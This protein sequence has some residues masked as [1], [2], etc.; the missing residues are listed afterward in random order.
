MRSIKIAMLIVVAWCGSNSSP[1]QTWTQTSAPSNSWTTI[2]SSADGSKMAASAKNGIWISTNSGGT[3]IQASPPDTN[4]V[5]VVL[6]ADGS[7]LAAITSNL[8]FISTDMGATWASNVVSNNAGSSLMGSI[9]SSADGNTLV[10]GFMGGPIDISTNSGTTWTACWWGNET[11]EPNPSYRDWTSLGSSADGTKL[12]TTGGGLTCGR[13]CA[14]TN[15]GSTWRDISINNGFATAQS[16]A[17]SPNGNT[18]A[19][20]GNNLYGSGAVFTSTNFGITWAP[21][22]PPTSIARDVAVSADGT[23][24]AAVF[25]DGGIYTSTNSGS[26]WTSNK[27]AGVSWYSVASSADGNILIA[28]EQHGGIWTCRTTPSPQL[29]LAPLSASLT[30]AWMVPSTNFVMQQSSDLLNWADMTNQ[31]V[32]NLT[33]LQD[34]VILPPPGSNVFYR[35]KTP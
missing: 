26:T 15:S 29:S 30:L 13:L 7:Q 25:N 20:V 2:A 3:W 11:H 18:L 8:V 14:S 4:W 32:L 17:I 23:R 6:S 10:V 21:F 1:A 31:P 28:A 5:S 19:F 35:L 12:F 24:L 22:Y 33:N 16:V 9:A 27:V 34:E